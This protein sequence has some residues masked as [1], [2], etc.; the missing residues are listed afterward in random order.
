MLRFSTGVPITHYKCLVRLV[1]CLGCHEERL[2]RGW[3]SGVPGLGTLL[4][5][6]RKDGLLRPESLIGLPRAREEV[7]AVE[8]VGIQAEGVVNATARAKCGGSCPR[9]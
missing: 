1:R 2:G 3:F 4:G 7:A 9:L 5:S 6:G 8:S